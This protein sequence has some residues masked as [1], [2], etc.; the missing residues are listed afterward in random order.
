MMEATGR[1]EA[2]SELAK[3]SVAVKGGT[4]SDKQLSPLS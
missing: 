4:S 2:M 1:A 3:S